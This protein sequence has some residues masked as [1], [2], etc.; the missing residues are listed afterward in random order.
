MKQVLYRKKQSLQN[1]RK[2]IAIKELSED[3][4]CKTHIRKSFIY[5]VSAAEQLKETIQ[6]PEIFI[7]KSFDSALNEEKFSFKV[8]GSFTMM[9]GRH[10]FRVDF[11]HTLKINIQWKKKLISPKKSVT[12]T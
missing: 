4:D 3:K 1:H 6:A 5:K 2:L 7:R 11:C 10:F 12:L 9:K 8:K